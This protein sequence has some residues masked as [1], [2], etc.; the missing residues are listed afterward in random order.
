MTLL[1]K[2]KQIR[3]NY[4]QNQSQIDAIKAIAS[5]GVGEFLLSNGLGYF[6][7]DHDYGT[8]Y[9][10]VLQNQEQDDESNIYALVIRDFKVSLTDLQSE[11]FKAR[12]ADGADTDVAFLVRCYGR[13]KSINESFEFDTWVRFEGRDFSNLRLIDYQG[14]PKNSF[15][16][17]DIEKA[18]LVKAFFGPNDLDDFILINQA[19]LSK[20]NMQ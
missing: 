10:I 14:I 17:F 11:L 2:M 3:L 8:E 1:E 18:A 16:A 19:S 5:A 6:S 13:V 7:I 12:T 9:T 15:T 4:L 20:D